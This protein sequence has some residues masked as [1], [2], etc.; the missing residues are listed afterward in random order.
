M[1]RD[2]FLYRLKAWP[3]LRFESVIITFEEDSYQLYA[4]DPG[5]PG[6]SRL[7]LCKEES[8]SRAQQMKLTMIS[9]I[10]LD[11]KPKRRYR[12]E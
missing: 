12:N 8:E 7:W 2:E 11:Y 9:W 10:R 1:R 6:G 4:V 3:K 5:F